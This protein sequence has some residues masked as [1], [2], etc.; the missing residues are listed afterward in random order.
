MNEMEQYNKDYLKG[1]LKIKS[2]THS[3]EYD[4]S[5]M[6]RE[7]EHSLKLNASTGKLGGAWQ[8]HS[9]DEIYL[10]LKQDKMSRW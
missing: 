2:N 7:V 1:T 9:D 10:I 3:N 4:I 5:G 8:L 6:Q